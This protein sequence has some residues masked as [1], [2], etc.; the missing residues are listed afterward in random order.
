MRVAGLF[1]GM[2]IYTTGVLNRRAR[3]L[4]DTTVV[5]VRHPRLP[6]PSAARGY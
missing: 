1:A 6:W 4:I 3:T 2:A 5:G